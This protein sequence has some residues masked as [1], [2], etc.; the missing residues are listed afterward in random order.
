MV[1]AIPLRVPSNLSLLGPVYSNAA[2]TGV[3]KTNRRE[4]SK[5][6]R[7]Y[8]LEHFSRHVVPYSYRSPE[9]PPIV[10]LDTKLSAAS[11]CVPS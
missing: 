2:N 7:G 5:A 3:K 4:R 8:C 10:V 6:F 1:L 11:E 9:T